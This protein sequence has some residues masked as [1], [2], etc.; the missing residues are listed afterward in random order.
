MG[1]WRGLG[2]VDRVVY[3]RAGGER[4]LLDGGCLC[5]YCGGFDE[6]AQDRGVDELEEEERLEDGV[7][8]L[9]RLAEQLGG[10]GWVGH[11]QAFHL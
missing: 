4:L 10:F 5:G 2:R 6:R 1:C 9:G 3:R 11:D 8:E 7:G